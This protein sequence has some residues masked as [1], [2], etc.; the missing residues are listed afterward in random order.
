MDQQT[1]KFYFAD[2]SPLVF[3]FPFFLYAEQKF[4]GNDRVE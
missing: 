3:G 1:V 2:N 4:W